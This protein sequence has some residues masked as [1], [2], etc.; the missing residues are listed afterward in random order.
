MLLFSWDIYTFLLA[1]NELW[2]IFAT[3]VVVQNYIPPAYF[4]AKIL[5]WFLTL[6]TTKCCTPQCQLVSLSRMSWVLWP[7]SVKIHGRPLSSWKTIISKTYESLATL[8]MI[9][10]GFDV[11]PNV[12][13]VLLCIA[14]SRSKTTVL[15]HDLLAILTVVG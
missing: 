15:M 1:Y 3:I 13:Y 6:H 4:Q 10:R 12:S 7:L 9:L 5:Q 11:S 8:G 2:Y 14:R